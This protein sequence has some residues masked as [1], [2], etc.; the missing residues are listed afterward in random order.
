MPWIKKHFSI[1]KSNTTLAM[2]VKDR[3]KVT[4]A[5]RIIV[6]PFTK[7]TWLMLLISVTGVPFF[8]ASIMQVQF[9]IL[10]PATVASVVLVLLFHCARNI[11]LGLETTLT[12]EA[13]TFPQA[14]FQPQVPSYVNLSRIKAIHIQRYRFNFKEANPEKRS[15]A[16]LKA[17]I[18]THARIE[19]N[20]GEKLNISRANLFALP[21]I[22]E[23]IN[24]KYSPTISF[25]YPTP[26]KVIILVF[27]LYLA[28]L[29]LS[30]V[31]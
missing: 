24:D 13:I 22:I 7:L 2:K 21:E 10:L 18:Y 17:E 15:R 30:K 26:I 11:K 1:F 9:D 31:V 8:L 16:I 3:E 29:Y 14:F 28:G 27:M 6:R 19:L 23:Y 12:K 20:T 25:A 4:F 5:S